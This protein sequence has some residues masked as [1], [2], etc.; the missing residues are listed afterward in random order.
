MRSEYHA[1]SF[2]IYLVPDIS[3]RT[4]HDLAHVTTMLVTYDDWD[5]T[6]PRPLCSQR[7]SWGESDENAVVAL[8]SSLSLHYC[9][10]T[11]AHEIAATKFTANVFIVRWCWLCAYRY[12][13]RSFTC[14]KITR[15]ALKRSTNSYVACSFANETYK[16]KLVHCIIRLW[17]PR[18]QTTGAGERWNL[19]AFVQ[20]DPVEFWTQ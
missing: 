8:S 14:I 19:L 18:I 12:D 9:T 10:S 3:Y 2:S 11:T 17:Q 20:H 5:S 13:Y 4:G 6:W 16:I 7:Q 15:I 1:R